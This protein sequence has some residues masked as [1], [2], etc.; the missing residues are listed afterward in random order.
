MLTLLVWRIIIR[1]IPKTMNCVSVLLLLTTGTFA[2]VVVTPNL[3]LKVTS[4]RKA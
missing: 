1:V 4:H 2:I 3:P